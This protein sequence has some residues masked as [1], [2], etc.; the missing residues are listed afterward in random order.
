MAKLDSIFPSFPLDSGDRIQSL[1]HTRKRLEDPKLLSDPNI[2][3]FLN[4]NNFIYKEEY[5]VKSKLTST[6]SL[7]ACLESTSDYEN[8][9]CQRTQ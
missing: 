1:I 4:T 8:E 7:R 2:P 3:R 6:R 5:K 9:E